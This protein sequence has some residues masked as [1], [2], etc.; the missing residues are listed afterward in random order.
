MLMHHSQIE[1]V[2]CLQPHMFQTQLGNLHMPVMFH[3]AGLHTCTVMGTFVFMCHMTSKHIAQMK[4]MLSFIRAKTPT[5]V[6]DISSCRS[7]RTEHVQL[8]VLQ[9]YKDSHR[10]ACVKSPEKL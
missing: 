5:S 1:K 9:T 3:Y 10:E 2:I 7:D 4:P 8:T 6:S